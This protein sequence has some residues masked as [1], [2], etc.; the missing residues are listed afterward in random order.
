M[1]GKRLSKDFTSG[2]IWRQLLFFSLPF[3]ASN[4]MQVLYS[5]IDMIIVGEYVG[6][7]GL[8]AVSQSSQVINFAVMVCLGFSNAGQVLVAQALGAKKHKEMSDII[9]TLFCFVVLLSVAL[10]AVILFGSTWILNAINI[11]PESEEMAMEYLIICGAGLIFT[12]GYNMVS[13]VLRGMGDAKRPFLFIGIASVVNLVLDI[14][15][16]GI[17]GW[18]V[19]GAAWA[20]IIGQAVSFLFSLVF[21]YHNRKA[22]GFEFHRKSFS[23]NKRYAG[24][25]TAL[26]TPMAIQSGFINV[27]MLFVNAMINEVGV[28]ASATFGVGIRIDDIVNKICMGIQYAAMPMISQNMGANRPDRAKKVVYSAWVYSGVLT[29][30]FIVLY[31]VLGKQLFMLFSNDV[32]VHEM[33]GTF[34]SAIL[35]MFP[36]FAIMRG[37]GAFVQ[38]IGNARFSMILALLDGVILR[39][40]LSYLLGIVCN[41][42]FYGFVLGYGLAPYGFAIPSLIYFLSGVWK[43]QQTLAEKI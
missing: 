21:L 1:K 9:G 4:A 11:P 42:G 33:S 41:L 43:K 22:F 38:G 13:A 39:I 17:W 5:T 28:V 16:T 34:I 19:A 2:N 26:G 15:F 24:M 3:M 35:W 6:T 23:L 18:G 31:V 37:S 20:T 8:S 25:I 7:A 32:Q 14:L 30:L 12:A 10:S 36:A 40:G 27:S 29:V